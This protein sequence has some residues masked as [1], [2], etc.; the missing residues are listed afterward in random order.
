MDGEP[1]WRH[2]GRN[3][4]TLAP[5]AFCCTVAG[6]LLD[7]ATTIVCALNAVSAQQAIA[8]AL[9]AG[10]ITAGGMIALLVP[11]PWAAWRRGFQQGSAAAVRCDA[12][13]TM[14]DLTAKN[15]GNVRLS[16]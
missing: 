6:T 14:V 8:M 9:P 4:L 13:P 15:V 11:D 1:A 2:P 5:R 12:C 3:C 16:V 10:L 7:V